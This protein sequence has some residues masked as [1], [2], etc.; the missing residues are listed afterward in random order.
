[1]KDATEEARTR[2]IS[3]LKIDTPEV[4]DQLMKLA[5]LSQADGHDSNSIAIVNPLKDKVQNED[6]DKS[7]FINASTSQKSPEEPITL[8]EISLKSLDSG[9]VQTSSNTSDADTLKWIK[10]YHNLTHST[11]D[12]M[13]AEAKRRG[14]INLILRKLCEQKYF[15]C[16]DCKK[17]QIKRYGWVRLKSVLEDEPMRRVIIDLVVMDVGRHDEKYLDKAI[18]RPQ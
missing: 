5:D 12:A 18:K 3:P 4:Y 16:V 10:Q 13:F 1:M 6:I 11:V 2:I 14:L 9:K 15:K 7:I 17:N 8:G